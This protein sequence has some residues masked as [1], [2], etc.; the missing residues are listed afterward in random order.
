MQSKIT[1]LEP[2]QEKWI[3]YYVNG[4]ECDRHAIYQTI[5][6]NKFYTGEI[7]LDKK[8]HFELHQK[9][10]IEESENNRFR[11]EIVKN[12]KSY[13]QYSNFSLNTKQFTDKFAP[14]SSE[15]KILIANMIFT[16]DM[17]YE[18]QENYNENYKN[19]NIATRSCLNFY[20]EQISDPNAPYDLLMGE[21]GLEQLAFSFDIMALSISMHMH[22]QDNKKTDHVKI[23]DLEFDMSSI[24]ETWNED[25]ANNKKSQFMKIFLSVMLKQTD[26]IYQCFLKTDLLADESSKNIM[27]HKFEKFKEVIKTL[28]EKKDLI[29]NSVLNQF[30]L[31]NITSFFYK[32]TPQLNEEVSNT[33]NNLVIKKV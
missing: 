24:K 29:D 30:N 1:Y 15:F 14:T 21:I 32:N 9:T 23:P 10:I 8:Y 3:K 12:D 6:D 25:W 18:A 16:L 13:N 19:L 33:N 11:R 26:V 28:Q 17:F 20:L 27:Q 4:E 31:S 5:L 2:V 22:K 7:T